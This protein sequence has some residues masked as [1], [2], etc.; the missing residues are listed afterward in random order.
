[1]RM[2]A[3]MRFAAVVLR[4]RSLFEQ[5]FDVLVANRGDLL[6]QAQAI[7]HEVYCDE[8]GWEHA[9]WGG[10][11]CDLYDPRA[12]HVLLRCRDSGE[13]VACGR[14]V[15]AEPIA[16]DLRLGLPGEAYAPAALDV[17]MLRA[18]AGEDLNVAEVT[19][20]AVRKA[21]RRRAGERG[22]PFS[23]TAMDYLGDV[24]Q[25]FPHI[26]VGLWLG[27]LVVSEQHGVDTLVTLNEPSLETHLRRTGMRMIQLGPAIDYHGPKVPTA[28]RVQQLIEDMPTVARPLYR[29][30]RQRIV[31]Q[32]DDAAPVRASPVARIR[33]SQVA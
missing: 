18:I 7:R 3:V 30:I 20:I 31:A 21:W 23:L 1:M 17:A 11:S 6:A 24:H 13:F 16:G 4:L 32:L 29:S 22:Q 27:L 25:R 9:Q 26:L 14:V 2:K 8:L 15:L 10:L 5:R 19:S 28:M 12:V 33:P